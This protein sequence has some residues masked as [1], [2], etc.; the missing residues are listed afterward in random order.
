[1][2]REVEKTP[3]GSMEAFVTLVIDVRGTL[4]VHKSHMPG[5]LGMESERPEDLL[6]IYIEVFDTQ[7]IEE[8]GPDMPPTK[9]S[10]RDSCW[11]NLRKNTQETGC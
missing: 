10:L 3:L 11:M 9:T 7:S 4:L 2:I 1:M 6:N 8:G 5:L